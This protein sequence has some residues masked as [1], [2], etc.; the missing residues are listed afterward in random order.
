MIKTAEDFISSVKNGKITA[1]EVVDMG[2]Q[3]Y[4]EPEI[5]IEEFS[6]F[7][8]KEITIENLG[9]EDNF[10]LVM[11]TL[12]NLE[13]YNEIESEKVNKLIKNSIALFI[14]ENEAE[15]VMEDEE[16]KEIMVGEF[17][18]NFQINIF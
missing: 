4:G 6:E 11:D 5:F 9:E 1:Q 8:P 12:I 13:E 14:D 7:F 10:S 17:Y 2:V 3:V 16:I 15:K 18:D